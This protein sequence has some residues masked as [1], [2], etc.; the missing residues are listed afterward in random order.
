MN[1]G[2]PI[3]RVRLFLA[4]VMATVPGL[5]SAAWQ[6]VATEQGKRVEIDHSSI[7]IA[8]G[9]PSTAT[10][11]I[12][13]DKP[14]V[15]TKTSASY[16]II[17]VENRYDCAERTYAT[18]KR[19]YYKD[20]G[21]LL[22][23]EEI[24]SPFDMPVR[25][26]TPDDRLL[27]EVCRPKAG[28]SAVAA[29]SKTVEKVSEV[30]DA[31]RKANEALVAKDLKKATAHAVVP[32]PKTPAAV[33]EA[34]NHEAPVTRPKARRNAPSVATRHG[35]AAH[36]NVP[37]SYEGAGGPENWG[38]ISAEY[39]T[40]GTGQ[41]QS[42]IDLREGILVDL[43]PIQFAYQPSPFSV[44]DNGHSIQVS[45]AGGSLSLLGKHYQLVQLHFHTPSEE[46]ING[47][48]LDMVVHMVH[49][50]N[51]G[52]QAVVAVLLEK[53]SENPFIQT[54]WNNLPLEK[55]EVVMPPALTLDPGR[56]LP[57][58][59]AYYTYM[60]SLTTPPCTEG[61]LWLVLKQPQTISAEQLA[62]FSRFYKSNVR[63]VQPGF[64]RI[65]KESR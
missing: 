21:E 15:D 35:A 25:S 5:A 14:I 19:R 8:P 12:V 44:V 16:R 20:E 56:L 10:G 6:V 3:R 43:E 51:D 11:R 36:A 41:R 38:K 64:G 61:V 57:E 34:E 42:P 18:L 2:S 32:S 63:P 13:L 23:Q 22:R 26:G 45:I 1:V 27:R 28:N 47:K 65:I 54:V 58:N 53:G 62:I 48:P 33:L 50:S 39:A 37:W 29:A 40:C 49:Q 60:G 17:E 31:L 59:H 46:W 7:I 55:N 30:S 9:K 4:L 52:K 24:R